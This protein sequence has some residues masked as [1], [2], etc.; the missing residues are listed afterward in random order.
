MVIKTFIVNSF[1]KEPFKGNPAGV[2]LLDKPIDAEIMQSIATELNLSETAFLL[3]S[4]TSSRNFKIRYFT[5]TVEVDFCGHA[6]LAASKIILDKSHNSNVDFTTHKG[7]QLSARIESDYIKMIFPLYD[8]TE[9]IP[10]QQLYDA[11]GIEN[12]VM[13]RFSKDLNMLIIEVKDKQTL[14]NI[15]PNYQKAIKSSDSIKEVVI[16]SKSE[17]RN[18]DFYS[19]CFCPWIGINEDPVTGASHSVL[20]KYWSYILNKKQMSAFQLSKRGGFLK[21]KIISNTE[22]EV[23]SNA[24]IVFE[25]EMKL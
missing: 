18:Y 6:T 3:E 1:T 2:C 24:R 8:T 17:D 14:L 5:P 16:T 20:A 15:K 11:F 13:T 9:F 23:R 21:L 12:P 7:L 10:N 22:L 25:G 19:R 4:K